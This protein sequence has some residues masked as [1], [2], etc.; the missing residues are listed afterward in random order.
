MV[1]VGNDPM[2]G[3]REM[4]DRKTLSLPAHDSALAKAVYS[5]NTKCVMAVVSSYP[6]SI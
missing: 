1:C 6:F 2:I 5:A 3:A 4:Y